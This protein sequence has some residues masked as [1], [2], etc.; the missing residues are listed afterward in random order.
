MAALPLSTTSLADPTLKL[1][2]HFYTQYCIPI[3]LGLGLSLLLYPEFIKLAPM[4]P[5]DPQTTKN[6]L[7]VLSVLIIMGLAY[8]AR[9]NTH[10]WKNYWR[11]IIAYSLV[12]L[13]VTLHHDQS[14]AF[15]L[16]GL[17]I[18]G[19]A[20]IGLESHHWYR[21]LTPPS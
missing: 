15:T 3:R 5:P 19:D 14:F 7:L 1:S 11:T 4:P 20:L 9:I 21:I 17:F 6:G 13:V 10:S 16:A 18:I 8:K 2:P 12:I